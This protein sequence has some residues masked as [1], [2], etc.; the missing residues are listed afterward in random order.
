VY[1]LRT[2]LLR[3]FTLF[4]ML[5]VL[6]A[7][8]IMRSR[9]P[10]DAGLSIPAESE[11]VRTAGSW[12][13]RRVQE[14]L[15][16]LYTFEEHRGQTLKDQTDTPLDL[17]ATSNEPL[18]WRE[19]GLQL[20]GHTILTSLSPAAK[21]SSICR[22]RHTFTIEAW[23]TPASSE[24]PEEAY[25]ITLSTPEAR[26]LALG[27]GGIRGDAAGRL[28]GRSSTA[29]PTGKMCPVLA[30]PD[31]LR[32]ELTHLVLTGAITGRRVLYLNGQVVASDDVLGDLSNWD[33]EGQ[34][35]IGGDPNAP[36]GWQGRV[37]LAAIYDHALSASE[38]RQNFAQGMGSLG[39][40]PED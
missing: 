19:G 9:M 36:F 6:A 32:P 8:Y 12:L 11:R 17:V 21:I 28:I 18:V 23:F 20:D 27:Q 40:R 22:E 16:A 7:V 10:M 29:S 15:L 37:H 31:V 1:N 3:V 30:C 39:L 26:D 4:L 34:L 35:S 38:V 33:P 24:S 5:G 13:D 14:G 2:A 25:I